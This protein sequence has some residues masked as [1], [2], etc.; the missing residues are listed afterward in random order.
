MFILVIRQKATPA[1]LA[2][3][4]PQPTCRPSGARA[5]QAVISFALLPLPHGCCCVCLGHFTPLRCVQPPCIHP[6]PELRRACWPPTDRSSHDERLKKNAVS[7][8]L[9]TASRPPSLGFFRQAVVGTRRR[10]AIQRTKGRPPKNHPQPPIKGAFSARNAGTDLRKQVT[11]KQK[12][13]TKKMSKVRRVPARP[14][15][16]QKA[17]PQGYLPTRR[18]AAP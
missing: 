12:K 9:L 8:A 18:T 3:F 10:P 6:Q 14:A 2:S 17:S 13:T 7:W 16:R 11:C 4:V 1:R 5:S 15:H